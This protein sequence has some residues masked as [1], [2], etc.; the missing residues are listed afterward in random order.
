MG[1]LSLNKRDYDIFISYAHAEKP[2]VQSLYAWLQ[3]VAGF[4]VWWD[5]RD[6]AAGA[7]LATE[8]QKGIGRC[9]AVV[10]VASDESL[11]RGWVQ[12][13]YNAAMDECA[14]FE[15]FRMV[16]LRMANANVDLL[17]KGI[18][19]IDVADVALTADLAAEI[20]RAL[21][22]GEKQPNPATSRDVY[23]SASWRADDNSSAKT[24]CRCLAEQG[25][26]LIG[27]ST[28]QKGFGAGNRIEQIMS[29]CGAFVGIIP[30]RGDDKAA[31]SEGPYKY[32][33]REVELA[34][35]LGLPSLV[36]ADPRVSPP[37]AVEWLPMQTEATT[38]PEIVKGPLQTLW[39]RW[40]VSPHP[41]YVF[42][43]MDLQSED[44]RLTSQ[45]RQL[46]QCITSMP[47]KVGN[48]V[49]EGNS[50]NVNAAVRR[51][52]CQAFLVLADLTDDNLNTCIEAG[53]ALAAETNVELIA[54][55]EPRRPPF[56]L[57]ERNMPTYTTRLQQIGLI[58]KLMRPYRRRV[59]NAE[60]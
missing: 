38:L 26:R 14:N 34:R 37:E 36:I 6:L 43:A 55:G 1:G 21:Y 35:R 11:S 18:S 5:S 19:W 45:I 24:V 52:V 32:F 15:G 53:M 40:R 39:D 58:H 47:T 20:I 2:F 30:F 13:E 7:S 60:L 28:D 16:V 27:D 50:E 10:L 51:A 31:A 44:T 9:R 59:I 57:R 17:M 48:E 3:D 23:I 41:H 8:L 46:I 12:K 25:L 54:S 56:M 29:S 4:Q 49:H 33:L 22:P 42:C